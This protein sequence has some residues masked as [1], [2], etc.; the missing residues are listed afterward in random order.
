MI[1]CTCIIINF[2][3]VIKSTTLLKKAQPNTF[4]LPYLIQCKF[5]FFYISIIIEQTSKQLLAFSYSWLFSPEIM[6]KKI[7]LFMKA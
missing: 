4:N 1:I 2:N 5:C 6:V 7:T 3:V